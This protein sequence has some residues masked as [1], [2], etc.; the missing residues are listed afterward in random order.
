M[1]S[2]LKGGLEALSLLWLAPEAVVVDELTVGGGPG[3]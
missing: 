1:Q 3:L 2:A